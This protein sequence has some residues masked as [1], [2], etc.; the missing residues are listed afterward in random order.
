[1]RQAQRLHIVKSLMNSQWARGAAV[2]LL[3][4]APALGNTSGYRFETVCHSSASTLTVQLI[5]EATGKPDTAAHVF[6]IHKQ[7]LPVKGEPR[8]LDRRVELRSNGRDG[9]IYDSND[10]QNGATVRLA[11]KIDGNNS[12]ILGSVRVCECGQ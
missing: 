7:W 8:S 12:D 2:A 3:L 11:A 9:F 10:V 6:A 5:N 1:M 4:T